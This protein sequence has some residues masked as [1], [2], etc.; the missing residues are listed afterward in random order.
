MCVHVCALEWED[1]RLLR[2]AGTQDVGAI[3]P[4]NPHPG[5]HVEHAYVRYHTGRMLN[6]QTAC[7]CCAQAV[8]IAAQHNAKVGDPSLR[9]AVSRL[10]AA[11][12]FTLVARAVPLTGGRATTGLWWLMSKF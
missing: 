3:N 11:R 12:P 4:T 9:Y 5:R 10:R 1:L 6:M 8:N 7:A 2:L